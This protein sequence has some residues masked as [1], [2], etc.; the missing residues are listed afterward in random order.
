MSTNV[1]G[2]DMGGTKILSAVIDAEGNILGTAKVPTKADAST[3]VVIDRIA[4]SIQQAIGKSGVN[5]AS[6][7]AV[8]IGAPGPLDPETGVV[9]FAPNLGWR[10]VPLKAELEARA[11]IPTFVDNDVNVGTLGEH[12]FG[13]GKG[14]QN[15]V[16]IFVG[17]GIG[18]GIILHGELF[19]GASKTAG[20]IGHIIVKADGPKCGCG[21]RGCLEA[22]ASRT[23]MTK[24]LQ[25]A[26]KKKGKKSVIS[27]LTDGDLSAIRSGVLAKAVRSNDKLTLKVFKKA[28][29]YLG[30]G[31]GS[32]VNFLNPEMIIL[33]GGVVEALDDTFLDNIRAA[34]E[35]YALP[36]TLDGVQIV[37]AKL[38]DNSGILGAAALARQRFLNY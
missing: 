15:V 12:A 16:G 18:G 4:D 3:S 37:R 21:T 9:I 36:N 14:V 8:G 1:V 32:I 17:T 13:A 20:E 7:E 31:I 28:T 11:G 5:A 25:K 22:L 38:G 6:I 27:K 33:G 23:A 35:K 10:D 2:V 19:H 34:A 29:K 30:V 24:Q 26:I